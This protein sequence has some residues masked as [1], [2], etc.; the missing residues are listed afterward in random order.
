MTTLSASERAALLAGFERTAYRLEQRLIYTVDVAS[1]AMNAWLAG[2]TEASLEETDPWYEQVRTAV[3][4]GKRYERVRVHLDE[5]TPYQQWLQWTSAHNY[6]AG[7]IMRYLT[8]SEADRLGVTEAVGDWWLL[9]EER[10]IWFD[11][12]EAEN[13]TAELVT[14]PGRVAEALQWWRVAAAHSATIEVPAS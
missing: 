13:Q 6:R 2:A 12:D 1:G 14:D 3:D 5:P 9:D 4:A 10:L 8:R 7:E 11:F